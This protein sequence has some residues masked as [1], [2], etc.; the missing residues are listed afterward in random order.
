[1]DTA[2]LF[3]NG[4]SQAVRLPKNCRFDASEVFVNKIGDIVMLIPKETK[5]QNL[6]A[7]LDLF[8]EDFMSESIESLQAEERSPFE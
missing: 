3:T 7:S 8:T 2:K 5:W 1:M 6:I 4:G